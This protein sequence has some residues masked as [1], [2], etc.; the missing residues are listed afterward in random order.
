MLFETFD[1]GK[2]RSLAHEIFDNHEHIWEYVEL[3]LSVPWFYA[4]YALSISKDESLR[5]TAFLSKVGQLIQMRQ[6][7]LINIKEVYLV[8]PPHINNLGKWSMDI[9]ENIYV[10]YERE[11]DHKQEAYVYA[12]T[13]GLRYVDSALG[14]SEK[15]LYSVRE[16]YG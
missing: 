9:I 4:N 7:D 5:R 1:N 16:I 13:N 10:G 11:C 6:T 12:L 15:E 14:S 8:S 2:C 3:T